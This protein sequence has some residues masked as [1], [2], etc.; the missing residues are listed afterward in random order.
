MKKVAVLNLQREKGLSTPCLRVLKSLERRSLYKIDW[1]G[2]DI[3]VQIRHFHLAG[4][5]M[6]ALSTCPAHVCTTRSFTI[7][8]RNLVRHK[9]RKAHLTDIPLYL[10]KA[11][12]IMAGYYGDAGTLQKRHGEELIKEGL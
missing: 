10:D 11:T 8:Y 6:V 3:L 5:N 12:P 4:V 1:K 9:F 7:A 2:T